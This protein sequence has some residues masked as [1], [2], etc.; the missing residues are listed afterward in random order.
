M[1][2]RFERWL[3]DGLHELDAAV[4]VDD[5]LLALPPL[6]QVASPPTRSILP[7]GS[8]AFGVVA[9][10]IA[11]FL[12]SRP[13]AAS[14]AAAA[15]SAPG[16]PSAFGSPPTAVG[17]DGIPMTIGGEPVLRDQA[18][19]AHILAASDATPF[20]V[21]GYTT[22]V[23]TDCFI[24]SGLPSSPLTAPCNDGWLLASEPG[25]AAL[26]PWP[27]PGAQGGVYRL[28]LSSGVPGW[29]K[30]SARS[31]YESTCATRGRPPVPKPSGK[32]ATTRSWSKRWLG[33]QPRPPRPS[34]APRSALKSSRIRLV[35]RPLPRRLW[36]ES[37]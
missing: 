12:I 33:Q 28:V 6:S 9:F 31:S 37:M 30:A 14:P 1:T 11:A 13:G 10:A 27:N 17:A 18:I 24:P 8:L 23:Q 21:A 5:G 20:L 4:P 35:S 25:G 32:P 36:H 34:R 7:L 22:F 26:A 3:E 19:A 2:E 16:A 29:P 15:P